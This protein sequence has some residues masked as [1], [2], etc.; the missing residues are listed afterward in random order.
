MLDRSLHRQSCY[1]VIHCTDLRYQLHALASFPGHSRDDGNRLRT[2]LLMHT[3][4]EHILQSH[5]K[6]HINV[7]H[8]VMTQQG[9][10]SSH[11]QERPPPVPSP[12][13]P[14]VPTGPPTPPPPPVLPP[15][16]GPALGPS[17]G[18]VC[19]CVCVCVHVCVCE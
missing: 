17:S 16:P 7:Q 9:E 1:T 11:D 19:V 14:P 13:P 18:C 15:V 2:R 6:F 4:S 12:P 8:S 5:Q 3:N 10:W